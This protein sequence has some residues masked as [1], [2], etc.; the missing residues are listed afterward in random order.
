MKENNFNAVR[1]SHYPQPAYF[2]ELCD[3]YGIYVCDEANI[4]SHG[5]YYSLK[6]GGTLGN[7][8]RFYKAHMA[9]IKNMYWRNKNYTSIIYWSMGNEAGN[10]YN[11]Y[12]TFL[13]L[14]SVEKI[15]P[16]QHERA[17][18]EWNTEIY[19]PQ[20]PNAFT[21]AKWAAQDTDRPYIMSE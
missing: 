1:C 18:L 3:E 14:K 7:D 2:Y 13:Y 10:G 5:M 16:V 11:F 20:Y 12:E 9:R 21:L 4:E 8:L 19:C 17:L 6:K 15:R